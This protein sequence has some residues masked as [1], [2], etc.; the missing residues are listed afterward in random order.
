M[1]S[2]YGWTSQSELSYPHGGM[3]SPGDFVVLLQTRAASENLRQPKLSDSTLHMANLALG[4]SWSLDPLRR[5]P[6]NTTYHVGMG[7]SLWRPLLGF[8]IEGRRDG[9]CDPGVQRRRPAGDDQVAV[10]LVARTRT[11]I[12]ITSPRTDEGSV[13]AKRRC[14]CVDWLLIRRF[15]NFRWRFQ[16]CTALPP[17][18]EVRSDVDGNENRIIRRGPEDL[19]YQEGE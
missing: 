2:R 7:Q 15:Q 6:S 16:E 10:G 9:L 17:V 1:S 13:C 3:E 4:W 14:H 12:A 19:R 11:A 5:F 8:D 18:Q